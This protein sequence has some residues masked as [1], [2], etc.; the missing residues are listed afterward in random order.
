MKLF[1][2]SDRIPSYPS[3]I[4]A[5]ILG[6]IIG[7]ILFLLIGCSGDDIAP[8]PD[9]FCLYMRPPIGTNGQNLGAQPWPFVRCDP[10]PYYTPSSI[11]YKGFSTVDCDCRAFY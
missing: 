8:D 1:K 4:S 3:A 11:T 6:W 9:S 5:V 7:L 2:Q 10:N